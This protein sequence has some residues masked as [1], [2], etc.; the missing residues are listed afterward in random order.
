MR[1]GRRNDSTAVGE[2]TKYLAV[3]SLL[4]TI[5]HFDSSIYL[6]N[7]NPA[8]SRLHRALTSGTPTR[9]HHTRPR[10]TTIVRPRSLSLF[11]PVHF[12]PEQTNKNI[13]PISTPV[14]S[15]TRIRLG[16][17]TVF[18]SSVQ[19]ITTS[20]TRTCENLQPSVAPST[21]AA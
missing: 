10:T 13:K 3:L 19:P 20:H 6:H 14:L 15:P 21:T 9:L 8:C 4:F 17:P 5:D 2:S 18:H 11:D 1:E 12:I 7:R 16:T